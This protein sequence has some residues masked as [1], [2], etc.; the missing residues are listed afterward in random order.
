MPK[1]LIVLLVLLVVVVGLILFAYFRFFGISKAQKYSRCA[2]TCEKAM[3]NAS[4]IEA[5]KME[6]EEITGYTPK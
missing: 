1:W 2:E 6:C 4:N 3:F 5:C